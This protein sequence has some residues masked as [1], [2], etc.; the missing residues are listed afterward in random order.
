MTLSPVGRDLDR[1]DARPKVTGRARYAADYQAQGK[2]YGFLVQ[3]TIGKGTVRAMDTAAAAKAPG[4]VAVYT[5][6]N[7]LKLY[8]PAGGPIVENYAPL[9]DTRVRYRGQIIGLVV[10][11]TF[12]QARYAAGLVTATY[13]AQEPRTSL[14]AG[15]PGTT[16][17]GGEPGGA[18]RSTVLASGVDSIEDALRSS[19]VTVTTTVT[20]P[21]QSHAAMEPHAALAI[22]HEGHLTIH[23]GTQAPAIHAQSIAARIGVE[24]DRVRVVNPYVGGGFGSKAPTWSEP[25]LAAAAARDLERPVKLVLTREQVFVL[26]GHRS[27][28][29]QRVRLGASAD[30]TLKVVAHESDAEDPAVSAW[31]MLPAQGTSTLLYKTENLAVDQR[32]VELDVPP[33]CA[34]RGPGESPGAFAVETAMDELADKLGMDPLELRRK[35]YAV[36]VPGTQLRWSGKHLDECYGVGA[37]RFGWSRRSPRPRSRRE[38]DWLI[39]MGMATAIYGGGRI[40]AQARVGFE[41]DGT[42]TVGTATADLGTGARTVIAVTAADALGIP[43]QRVTADLG[44]SALPQ[45]AMAAGSLATASSVPAVQAAAR[46]AVTAL[47]DQAVGN[48]RSPFHGLDKD[49]VTYS[50]G[51]ISGGGRSVTFR[52]L[53]QTIDLPRVQA[54]AGSSAP[55]PPDQYAL[56]SFGAHFCEVKV[57]RLTGEPRVTR[58]TTV[59]DAGRIMSARTTRSQISGAVIFGIGHALLEANPMEESGR[60]AAGN[61]ADYLVPVNADIP[62]LDVHYLDRPDPVVS[63]LGAR[64]LGELP[65][66][67]VAA[68]IGNAVHNATGIRVRDL[69]ITLD[70]L[71][72]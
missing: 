70:K 63:E 61:L 38:G 24:P 28:V 1:V 54:T 55:P 66:V 56:N 47:I 7:P 41:A 27:A 23:T 34:M 11:E 9:Q 69:P 3:A 29:T 46:A 35:N 36:T 4:V 37:E 53:L 6:F 2:A 57:H 42:A 14:P 30:G 45:G 60:F 10:A 58:F 43:L 48:E 40:P 5:P 12:E 25:V 68:A 17:P 65:S 8:A 72:G 20:Q 26:T 16:A 50:D 33:V 51:R 39:G 32:L 15:S 52:R 44:D 67:G 19:D 13:D 64:G 22:W 31:P 21:A 62:D 59:I 71:L 18:A 49:D